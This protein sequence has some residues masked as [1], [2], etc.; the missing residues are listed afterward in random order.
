MKVKAQMIFILHKRPVIAH[1]VFP[2]D[3]P[4]YTGR[5]QPCQKGF[6]LRLR[7]FKIYLANRML[8]AFKDISNTKLQRIPLYAFFCLLNQR[9]IFI[10][11]N[12]RDRAMLRIGKKRLLYGCMLQADILLYL[13]RQQ[14]ASLN[15]EVGIFLYQHTLI[16]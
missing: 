6:F 7:C 14:S 4:S 16:R 9:Y 5:G 11:R 8:P 10:H 15:I 13:Y 2:A 3:A 1:L 12:V